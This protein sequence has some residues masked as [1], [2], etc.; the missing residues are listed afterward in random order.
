MTILPSQQTVG[1]GKTKKTSRP[2]LELYQQLCSL[3]VQG[4]VGIG[5]PVHTTPVIGPPVC[6]RSECTSQSLLKF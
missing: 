3:K 5:P 4:S 2:F 1:R 6:R